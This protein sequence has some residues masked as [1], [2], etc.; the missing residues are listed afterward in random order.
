MMMNN[1]MKRFLISLG[2][3]LIAVSVAAKV[4]TA[5]D[6]ACYIAG[7]SILCSVF[8]SDADALAYV[9]LYGDEGFVC[10]TKIA[11][12]SG[13]GGGSLQLPVTIPTGNYCL[14]SYTASGSADRQTL[15]IFNCFSTARCKSVRVDNS[16]ELSR[17][18]V[19]EVPS[20][21]LKYSV[22][23]G[24]L[25][26][27]NTS[28]KAFSGYLSL[29]LDDCLES[30][31]DDKSHSI[32][33]FTPDRLSQ[34]EAAAANARGGER[35][36][37]VIRGRIAG[38]DAESVVKV[39][40]LTALISFPGSMTDI[41]SARMNDDCTLVIPTENVYGNR[42]IACTLYGLPEGS[43]CHIEL[44]PERFSG[45]VPDIP[46]MVLSNSMAGALNARAAALVAQNR[47]SVTVTLPVRRP[48][49]F[50]ER[51]RR[52]FHLDDYNR[53]PTME[54]EF[55]EIL[56]LIRGVKRDGVRVIQVA[57]HDD[58]H[59]VNAFAWGNSLVM[60]DGVPVFDHS[61]VWNYDPALVSDVEIFPYS[62]AL[63]FRKYE[64]VVNFK[65]FKGNLPGVV[66]DDNVRFYDFVGCSFPTVHHGT[67]TLWWHPLVEL[68]PGAVLRLDCSGAAA[69]QYKIT[70][71]GI[72]ADGSIMNL[73]GVISL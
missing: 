16:V 17:P 41:Y 11:L 61:I 35:D 7:E 3:G 55:V 25:L 50:F 32:T 34:R 24:H 4:Y 20:F 45:P 8:C 58:A 13:R 26:V 36:G 23:D 69:G 64:G 6:K 28:S 65:T 10:Q 40:A 37:D 15:A 30:Q 19:R 9:E 73:S 2:F 47:D 51:E 54:E 42:D 72:A 56:K 44:E 12:D 1:N 67:N 59:D 53:F 5:T 52:V 60:I 57:S 38:P 48:H 27:E 22:E 18:G 31:Y 14:V 29:V 68:E 21:G 70:A 71:E 49:F 39:E 62:Y 46:A 33:F 66:F 43:R 63:G